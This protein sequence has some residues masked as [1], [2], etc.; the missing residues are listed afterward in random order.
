MHTTS[1]SITQNYISRRVIKGDRPK[2]SSFFLMLLFGKLRKIHPILSSLTST[3][4]STVDRCV[5]VDRNLAS[6]I[7]LNFPTSFINGKLVKTS[8]SLTKCQEGALAP[9]CD[10]ATTKKS[11]GSHHHMVRPAFPPSVEVQPSFCSF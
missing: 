9:K 11:T 5:D 2:I 7:F 8:S 1:R 6:S 4:R 10:Q 3:H